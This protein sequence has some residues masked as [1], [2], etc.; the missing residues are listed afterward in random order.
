MDPDPRRRRREGFHLAQQLAL[1]NHDVVV[2][3][4]DRDRAPLIAG[5]RWTRWSWRGTAPA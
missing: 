1:E 5:L 4:Q 2:I 3:E